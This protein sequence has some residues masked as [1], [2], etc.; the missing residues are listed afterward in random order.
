MRSTATTRSVAQLF[1]AFALVALGTALVMA[2]DLLLPNVTQSG[3]QQ[4]AVRLAV[5]AVLLYG[6]SLALSRAQFS[7]RAHLTAWLAIAVPLLVWQSVVRWLA[8]AGAFQGRIGPAPL[9]PLTIVLPLLIGL[10]ILLNSN[11]IGQMPTQRRRPGSSACRSI[12]F[13]AAPF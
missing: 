8:L 1:G 10:P 7:G 9:L 12:A 4:N 5:L 6:A 2:T 3:L 11:T 13:S